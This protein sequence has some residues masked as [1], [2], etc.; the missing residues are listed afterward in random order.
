[1][2]SPVRMVAQGLLGRERVSLA[3][4]VISTPLPPQSPA[5]TAQAY[6]A[7]DDAQVVE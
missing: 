3:E 4:T 5:R 2:V 7:L 6:A 1:M